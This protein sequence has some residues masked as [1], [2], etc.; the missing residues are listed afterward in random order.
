MI[1]KTAGPNGNVKLTF[2]V[3]D[4]GSP[5]SVVGNF[6]DWDPAVHPLRKRSN[7]TRSTSVT[8]PAGSVLQFRYLAE[9]GKWF[10]DPDGQIEPNGLGQTHT[11]IAS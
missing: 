11:V 5:A 10:D 4:D 3:T 6:N 2:A 9:G 7:G 1:R 8:V